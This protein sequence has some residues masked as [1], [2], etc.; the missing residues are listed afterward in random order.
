VGVL[1]SLSIC[2]GF[3]PSVAS[4]NH[5]I[6]HW[7]LIGGYLPPGNYDCIWYTSAGICSGWN[8]WL[9]VYGQ[10]SCTNDS[11]VHTGF[12][13][14]DRIR[15]TYLSPCQSTTVYPE[16]VGMGGYLKAGTVEVTQAGSADYVVTE[17]YA[18]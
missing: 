15:G 2:A 10:T 8:Y 14:N 4:A 7:G 11:D 6:G 12:Q 1:V 17:A 18:S 9:N 5:R 13:N 3:A 16:L